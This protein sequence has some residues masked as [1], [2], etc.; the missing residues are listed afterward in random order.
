M[1]ESVSFVCKTSLAAALTLKMEH[2]LLQKTF[3]KN[4]DVLKYYPATFFFQ[5]QEL[6]DGQ[7]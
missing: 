7:E 6:L 2:F 3:I 5:L 1:M 4:C